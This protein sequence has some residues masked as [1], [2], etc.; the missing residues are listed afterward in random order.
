MT[1]GRI[2]AERRRRKPTK[3]GV[4][5]SE[6]VIV[7]CALRLVGQH[8]PDALSVRRLGAALG[9]D[10]SALYRYFHNTD[11]L[12]LAVADR[13]IGISMAG[14][15]PETMPWQDGLR[16]MAHRIHRGY[17]EHPRVAALAAYRVTR[18]EHE[19]RSVEAGIGLM[20]RAGFGP[21]DAVRHYSAFVDTVLGHAA[22]DAAHLALPVE[23]RRADDEAWAGTYAEIAADT[24]PQLAA[25]RGYLPLMAGSSFEA[26]L[27]LVVAAL[28]AAAP[29]E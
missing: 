23:R 10:P 20:R 18:R 5:L 7:D 25:V 21:E 12:L 9:C 16:E 2:P 13:I 11:D 29:G 3:S 8:G 15:A 14:F 24:H 22:L 6:D 28:A 27:E 26:A 1:E 17:R 4:L 19:F